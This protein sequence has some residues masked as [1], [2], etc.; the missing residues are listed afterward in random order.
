MLWGWR[1]SADQCIQCV[2][3]PVIQEGRVKIT[4]KCGCVVVWGCEGSGGAGEEEWGGAGQGVCVEGGAAGD[5]V[6]PV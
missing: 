6:H 1:G 4:V 3:S 5:L 2:Q